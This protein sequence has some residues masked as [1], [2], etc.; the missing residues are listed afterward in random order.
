MRTTTN[1]SEMKKGVHD[2]RL[3]DWKF[4]TTDEEM[5][6]SG[7]EGAFKGLKLPKEVIDKIYRKNAEKWLPGIPKSSG[8]AN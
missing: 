8:V 1:S 4:F 5:N 6:S 3:R 2:G 7:F